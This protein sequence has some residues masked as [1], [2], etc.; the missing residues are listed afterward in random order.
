MTWT[1]GF[2]PGRERAI[3]T[4]ANLLLNQV[5]DEKLRDQRPE[6]IASRDKFYAEIAADLK[7]A[8]IQSDYVGFGTDSQK[9]EILFVRRD[10]LRVA[11]D[12][13]GEVREWFPEPDVQR[14]AS[15]IAEAVTFARPTGP[16]A[17]IGRLISR[18]RRRSP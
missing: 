11:I 4:F 3:R 2:P 5:Q 1:E 15:A 12:R 9:G 8:L 7:T 6:T 16:F 14:T 17:R 10:G 13:D 18:L